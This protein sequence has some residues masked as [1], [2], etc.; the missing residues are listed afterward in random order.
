MKF[1]RLAPLI[2]V[3]AT[4]VA[5]TS[6]S[7]DLNQESDERWRATEGD[8]AE[9]ADHFEEPEP[10]R[11]TITEEVEEAPE[12]SVDTEPPEVEPQ[13]ALELIVGA[14][15]PQ[16][17]AFI[18]GI[19]EYRSVPPTPGARRDAENFAQLLQTTMGVPDQNIHLLVD[20][21]ATRTDIVATLSMLQDEVD[22]D[23]RI[24]FFFSGHGTPEVQSGESYL[25]PYEGR[26]ETI[27]HSGIALDEILDGLEETPAQEVFAFVDACFSGAGDRSTLPEG[28]R[29]LVPVQETEP[30]GDT[31]V[32]IMA[33]SAAQEISGTTADG[34]QGLF[35]HH[36]ISAI[37]EG[38]ADIDGDG[39]ISLSELHDF[40]APRVA[41]DAR[42]LDRDQ[43]PTISVSD[44][45][46][47]P[48][49][50][51]LLWGLPRN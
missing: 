19:D 47:D 33:S 40:V 3:F 21:D 6:F 35:S 5:C 22:S 37:G 46:R 50:V 41:R 31:R 39:Q 9:Y 20:N 45:L 23:G 34:D 49:A 28:T 26:P 42:D 7:I 43:T 32:A 25:M 51:M 13:E 14:P 12:P 11:Q 48:E 44:E 38:R 29:P 36:L 17:H 24:Y 18:V 8:A 15:Q 2:I 1:T 4:G 16:A 27:E 10:E 30:E